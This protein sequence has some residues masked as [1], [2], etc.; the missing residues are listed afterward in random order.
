MLT[1][2]KEKRGRKPKVLSLY[3]FITKWGDVHE[4]QAHHAG[5][6][7]TA[8]CP[9]YSLVGSIPRTLASTPSITKQSTI[10]TGGFCFAG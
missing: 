10:T 1:P 5:K 9:Q 7:T 4:T 2:I 6:I 8:T 3:V